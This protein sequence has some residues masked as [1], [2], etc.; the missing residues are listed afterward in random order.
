V[1]ETPATARLFVALPVSATMSRK[2]TLIQPPKRN[3]VRPIDRADLHITLHFLGGTEIASAGQAL[4]SVSAT[5]FSVGLKRPGHFS[6]RGQRTILSVGVDPT[7]ALI[8]LHTKTG[9]VLRAIGCELES[10][11]YLPHITLARL[12]A[13]APRGAVERFE[14]AVLPTDDIEC[15]RF[16]LYQSETTPEGSRYRVIESYP[17]LATS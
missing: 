3:G 2:L 14:Q 15:S 11:P 10:R 13:S 7:D 8:A 16:A 17:L 12:T 9:D 5:R 1:S 4:R 6:L